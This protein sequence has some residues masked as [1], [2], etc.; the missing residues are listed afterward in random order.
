[1][2]SGAESSFGEAEISF[3]EAESSLDDQEPSIL[4]Y[5]RYHG[6]ASYHMLDDDDDFDPRLIEAASFSFDDDDV[7]AL[8]NF[9]VDTGIL[10]EKLILDADARAV[11]AS[12]FQAG[13]KSETYPLEL[14][15]RRTKHVR[16]EEPLLFT[17]PK[18]DVKQYLGAR[19]A[20][21]TELRIDVDK[22]PLF[23]IDEQSDEALGW[24]EKY[25]TLPVKYDKH[26]ADEKIQV[27]KEALL[28][29][30]QVCQPGDTHEHI[31]AIMESEL[32][33]K[34]VCENFFC[35]VRQLTHDRT[36]QWNHLHLHCRL[37][38]P[39][40]IRRIRP[41]PSSSPF[42][43]L[44]GVMLLETMARTSLSMRPW[45][46]QKTFLVSKGVSTRTSMTR[47]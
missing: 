8:T 15:I 24:P 47:S 2:S 16:L 14:D 23:P 45:W 10:D 31:H 42:R 19:L 35:Y 5:A 11:L 17:D 44:Y 3:D 30:H 27:P 20:A 22:L 46:K 12:I 29:L 32:K 28:F 41:R 38:Y 9:V 4:E 21:Q 36:K 39:Y 18:L 13:Q 40:Q 7:N 1:M 6:L 26:I 43:T 25:H 33:Y 34:R 37:T